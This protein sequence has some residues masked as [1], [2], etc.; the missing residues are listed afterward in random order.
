MWMAFLSPKLIAE[1]IAG[2]TIQE[3][4]IAML[5]SKDVPLE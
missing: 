2:K 1:I 5:I 4:T 3:L